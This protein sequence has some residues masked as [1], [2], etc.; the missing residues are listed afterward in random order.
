MIEHTDDCEID[1]APGRCSCDFAERLARKHA[2]AQQKVEENRDAL[3]RGLAA[4]LEAESLRKMNEELTEENKQLRELADFW[5]GKAS[6]RADELTRL[7]GK[8]QLLTKVTP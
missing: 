6:R 5:E 4:I 1:S 8:L 3:E 2:I 7:R